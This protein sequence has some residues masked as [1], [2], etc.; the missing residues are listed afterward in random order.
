MCVGYRCNGFGKVRA[1][2]IDQDIEY[3][4]VTDH[5]PDC[6]AVGDIA[7]FR[8]DI[9]IST[10]YQI[11]YLLQTV[12]GPPHQY[13]VRPC[14][15]ECYGHGCTDAASSAGNQGCLAIQAE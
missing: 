8:F 11:G 14:L 4:Q 10:T 15:A 6:C 1:G 7:N 3:R 2:V 5:L 12:G 13:R 9:A